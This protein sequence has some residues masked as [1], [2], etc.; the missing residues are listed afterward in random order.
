MLQHCRRPCSELPGRT[1]GETVVRLM[2][3]CSPQGNANLFLI[4]ESECN[5]GWCIEWHERCFSTVEIV[6]VYNING[7]QD[8]KYVS[9]WFFFWSSM[10]LRHVRLLHR[11][12]C[13]WST[14]VCFLSKPTFMIS[15]SRNPYQRCKCQRHPQNVNNY[16]KAMNQ[17]KTLQ[18]CSLTFIV[19]NTVS[20]L[21]PL[22]L[23][24]EALTK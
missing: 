11:S 15:C 23:Y 6:D 14:Q 21:F 13:M 24:T 16:W 4:P 2:G 1:S 9:Y 12:G 5:R 7:Y 19:S 17:S 20:L 22:L 10:T 3:H 18:F 8:A